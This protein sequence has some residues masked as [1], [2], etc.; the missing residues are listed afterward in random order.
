[1][2]SLTFLNFISNSTF[3]MFLFPHK[4]S[5]IADHVFFSS[6]LSSLSAYFQYPFIWFSAS[7]HD[8]LR[9]DFLL[10]ILLEGQ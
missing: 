2:G 7:D 8:M 1:M 10:L 3:R 5:G 6:R 9:Y 4:K